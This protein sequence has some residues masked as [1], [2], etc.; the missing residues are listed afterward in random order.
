MELKTLENSLNVL[1]CFAKEKQYLGLREIARKLG[2]SHTAVHRIASTFERR[3]YLRR[4]P[5]SRKYTLGM[6]LLAHGFTLQRRLK[7]TDLIRPEMRDLSD[8]TGESVVLTW[9]DGYQGVYV[10]VV[11]GNQQVRFT[12]ELGVRS[13]LYAGASHKAML[14]FMPP[15]AVESIISQAPL[16]GPK[17]ID[18]AK[19]HADLELIRKQRWCY[20][21]G[22][23]VDGAA[24]LSV[25]IFNHRSEIAASLSIASPN[26][27]FSRDEA[28]KTL[29]LLRESESRVNG[30]FR[31]YHLGGSHSGVP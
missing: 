20:S 13:A 10:A 8:K 30:Y 23:Q 4:D 7:I 14:A 18:T 26:F 31:R 2:V 9:L 1:E 19:L 15:D 24:A 16:S 5:E 25:P 6:K 11:E 29:P 3:G 27:R 12:E 22:E 28:V 17:K 21:S